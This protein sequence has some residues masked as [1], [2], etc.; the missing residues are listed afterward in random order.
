LGDTLGGTAEA[1]SPK[2]R[3][4]RSLSWDHA[5]FAPAALVL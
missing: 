3:L 5:K 4:H 2:P 1:F